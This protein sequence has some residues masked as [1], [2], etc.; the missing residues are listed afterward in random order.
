MPAGSVPMWWVDP[1]KAQR[2]GQRKG[3]ATQP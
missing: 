1:A 3:Q 2:L